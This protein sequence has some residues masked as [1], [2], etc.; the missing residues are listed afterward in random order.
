MVALQMVTFKDFFGGLFHFWYDYYMSKT[1]NFDKACL[2][3][4]IAEAKH[5]F[6]EGNYPVGA[7]LA[8]GNKIAGQGNNTGETSKNYSNHA[9]TSLIIENGRALLQSVNKGETITLYSTLEPCLMCLGVAT[10]NKVDRIVYIQTDP[11]AGACGIDKTSLG[12]RYQETWPQIIHI[13]YSPEPKE[14][15]TEFLNKQ[16]ENGQRIE[17]SRNF[18]KLLTEST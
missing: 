13:P 10:M 11:H 14:M 2:D 16:I 12:V 18:L 17:W 9:E 3:L 8:I 5:S 6:S 1:N 4:A 7:I 15:I